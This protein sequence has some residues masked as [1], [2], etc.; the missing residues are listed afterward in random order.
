MNGVAQLFPWKSKRIKM[1]E[2]PPNG[3][4]TD[5]AQLL[6]GNQRESRWDKSPERGSERCSTAFSME[7]K[8]NQD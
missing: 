4:M 1:G 8:E 3:G 2:N 6:L 5:V 7:I